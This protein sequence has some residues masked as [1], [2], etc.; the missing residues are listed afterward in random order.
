MHIVIGVYYNNPATRL[1]THQSDSQAAQTAAG[2]WQHGLKFCYH[3][4]DDPAICILLACMFLR[5]TVA[6]ETVGAMVPVWMMAA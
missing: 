6:M 1:G 5:T 2:I 4:L 3:G